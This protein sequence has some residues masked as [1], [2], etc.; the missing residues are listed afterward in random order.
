MLRQYL[1]KIAKVGILG[2]FTGFIAIA[3][4]AQDLQAETI[5]FRDGTEISGK[6][7]GQN[8]NSVQLVSSEGE[9][10]T[11]PKKDILRILY[12]DDNLT[13]KKEELAIKELENKRIQSDTEMAEI[14]A[15]AQTPISKESQEL[16]ESKI[17]KS[18]QPRT[19]AT[20]A[21]FRSLVLPGWGQ[22]YQGR[23]IAGSIYTSLVLGGGYVVYDKN[24]VYRNAVNDYKK[25]DQPFSEAAIIGL[26]MGLPEKSYPE[27]ELVDTLY[28]GKSDT[29]TESYLKYQ[30]SPELLQKE[31]VKNHHQ[32][33]RSYSY[34]LAAIWLW[35]A[36]DAYLFHPKQN[37]EVLGF[38]ENIE[39]GN[40]YFGL[41]SK[42][43]LDPV[44]Y[45][46]GV[47]HKAFIQIQF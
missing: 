27:L 39:K 6:I 15:K 36:I 20:G 1:I 12:K 31:A 22:F 14:L 13:S 9:E 38:Q 42:P 44:S 17:R 3:I 26:A 30:N 4:V 18:L 45:Q 10:K 46:S 29:L 19:T 28:N 37:N 7:T 35:T 41:E 32:E 16:P 47:E 2:A 40:I 24:R 34:G 33:L 43:T 8:K 11:I 25:I 5:Y 23:P 21:F